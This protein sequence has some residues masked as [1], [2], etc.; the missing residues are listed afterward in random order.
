MKDLFVT[1][2]LK[3]KTYD[4]DFAGIVSNIVYIRWLE[5]LRLEILERYFP[6]EEQ[7]KRDIAPLLLSTNI[8]Y[9]NALNLYSRPVGRIWLSKLEKLRFHLEAEIVDQSFE[10]GKLS[11]RARQT[12]VF[13]DLKT[14]RPIPFPEELKKH[15][16]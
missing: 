11:V 14:K 16:S 6:I 13:I 1:L 7:L 8:R 15:I 4:I 9:L 5:D 10:E 12:G 3:V 2:P